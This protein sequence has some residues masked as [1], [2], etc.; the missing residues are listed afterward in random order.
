MS[1]PRSVGR[2][3]DVV[4]AAAADLLD[5][6]LVAIESGQIEATSAHAKRMVRRIEGAVT[7]LRHVSGV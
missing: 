5:R 4:A 7:A 1:R 6:L 2:D 3:P